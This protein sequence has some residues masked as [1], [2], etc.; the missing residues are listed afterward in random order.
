[1]I[2][3]ILKKEGAS[4]AGN[5]PFILTEGLKGETVKAT[6]DTSEQLLS[7]TLAK[8]IIIFESGTCFWFLSNGSFG[9]EGI[10]STKSLLQ[11]IMC[12]H[13]SNYEGYIIAQK[14]LLAIP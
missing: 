7:Q 12:R 6:I 9:I 11:N 10:E 4:S 13:K 8:H 14:V 2:S 5:M 1:M 3:E